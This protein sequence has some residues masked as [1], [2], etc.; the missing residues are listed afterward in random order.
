MHESEIYRSIGVNCRLV[1]VRHTVLT[2]NYSRL[3]HEL[4]HWAIT[5]H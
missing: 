1:T 5:P 3:W 4:R 2:P